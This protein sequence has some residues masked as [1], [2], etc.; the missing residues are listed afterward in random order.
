MIECSDWE[1][2]VAEAQKACNK[3]LEDDV[4][5]V[6]K[7]ILGEHI[8]SD[9]YSPDVY[10]PK[11]N[12]WVIKVGSKNGK[13]IWQRATYK[14][15]NKLPTKLTAELDGSGVL[16]VSSTERPM[17]PVRGKFGYVNRLKYGSLLYLLESDDMGLWRG[18]FPRP[19][20]TNAQNE[21]ADS[22][23]ISQKIEAGIKKRF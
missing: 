11:P 7:K 4:A 13:P 3:I 17:T 14:R 2:L 23:K 22:P 6:A 1:Q 16:V 19:A 8:L 5:P 18:G 20:L 15:R 9:I 12:G 10:T 21:M